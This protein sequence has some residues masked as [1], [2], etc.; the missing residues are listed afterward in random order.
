ME[1]VIEIKCKGAGELAPEEMSEFQGQLKELSK[2][3]YQKLRNQ[4]VAL[5]FS[6][7]IF[8]WKN[9]KNNFML[10][11]HQRLR[12]IQTMI[13]KEGYTCPKLPVVWIDAAN[14]REAKRKLLA[15]T[16]QYGNFTSQGLYEFMLEAEISMDE[17][18]ETFANPEIDLED[19]AN[20]YFNEPP[21]EVEED[22]IPEPP[23]NP[24]TKHGDVWIL[25]EQRVLCGDATHKLDEKTMPLGE[26]AILLTDPPYCSGGSQEAQKKAGTWGNIAADNL[27]TRGYSKLIEGVL[28]ATQFRAV[29]IFTDWRMWIPLY[30]VVEAK[31]HAVRSMIVWAKDN[32]AMGG[33][34]R[35]QHELVLFGSRENQA[36]RGGE[37][38][39]GNI[40]RSKRTQ[41]EH[42]YTEKP[43]DLIAQIIKNDQTSKH[44][45]DSVVVDTFAGS[46][47]TL[48][49]AEQVGRK[50]Y[51]IE[52]EPK[53]CDVIVKRWENLTGKKAKKA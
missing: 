25:G 12:V 46:G 30:D 43:V 10:D 14:K 29:Y 35:T 37:G 31:G 52:I 40:L 5:G 2:A 49:A 42:H 32:P 19:F 7:P 28:A 38:S 4:I 36:K 51:A 13:E 1:K 41:N 45:E 3:H 48:I 22:E 44:R 33:I 50:C 11:G 26:G 15:I 23:E 9:K 8:V 53:Y 6:A 34:W 18:A 20:E 21:A 24:I 17:V 47:T 27:S 39:A 16:S